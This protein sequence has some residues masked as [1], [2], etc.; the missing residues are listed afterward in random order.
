M[1]AQF[2]IPMATSIAFGLFFT[3]FLALLWL[4]AALGVYEAL[5]ARLARRF[6]RQVI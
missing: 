5:H 2:L 4:P 3:T 1:Q 6:G